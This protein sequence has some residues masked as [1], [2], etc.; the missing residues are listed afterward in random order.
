MSKNLRS[1][2]SLDVEFFGIRIGENGPTA[3][4]R[5]MPAALHFYAKDYLVAAESLKRQ[6]SDGFPFVHYY[7]VSHSLELALKAFLSAKGSRTRILKNSFNHS[8]R[9]LLAEAQRTGLPDLVCLQ[10]EHIEQI[11]RA[12]T[13][14]FENPVFQYPSISEMNGGIFLPKKCFP[15]KPNLP[16]L[17]AAARLILEGIEDF[18]FRE[19][20]G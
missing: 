1:E 4:C 5:L 7:L 18:C 10:Q 2:R 8:L 17:L 13:Y 16:V 14:Y 12:D 11:K 3:T 19:G 9:K 6:D 15:D 20:T